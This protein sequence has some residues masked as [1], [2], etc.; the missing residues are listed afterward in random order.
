VAAR[1]PRTAT[2]RLDFA[3][4]VFVALGVGLLLI[5]VVFELT[6]QPALLL[7]LLTGVDAVIVAILY[8]RRSR[9]SS[10]AGGGGD[11]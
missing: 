5:T 8:R 10:G 4:G 9:I 3:L 6:G 1:A 2:S 11:R 7:A